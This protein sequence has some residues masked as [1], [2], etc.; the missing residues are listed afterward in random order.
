MVSIQVTSPT[1]DQT[2]SD[3][4]RLLP[5]LS[6]ESILNP[7]AQWIRLETENELNYCLPNRIETGTKLFQKEEVFVVEVL[8]QVY[9]CGSED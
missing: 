2:V 5:T 4:G 7:I 8:S 1:T 3:G 6:W 9:S